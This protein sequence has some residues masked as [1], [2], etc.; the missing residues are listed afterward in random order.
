MVFKV[1]R[2]L[3]DPLEA[4]D[5]LGSPARPVPPDRPEPGFKD[6]PDQLETLAC[7][8]PLGPWDPLAQLGPWVQPEAP[9]L[10][11]L[12]VSRDR[13]DRREVPVPRDQMDPRALQDLLGSPGRMVLKDRRYSPGKPDP[14]DLRETQDPLA[15]LGTRVRKDP[16]DLRGPLA[17]LDHWAPRGSKDLLARPVFPAIPA[18]Q[19][20]LAQGGHRG[21]LVP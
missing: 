4:L 9:G 21:Q 19:A 7:R 13:L 12:M 8:D 17:P 15:Q 14:R 6:L 2:V 11:A 16:Q 3:R 10:Q 1:P 5:R 20:P 18:Q